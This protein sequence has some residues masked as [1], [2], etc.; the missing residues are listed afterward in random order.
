MKR[1]IFYLWDF[2]SRRSKRKRE[3]KPTGRYNWLL[4]KN[5][6]WNIC[7]TLY[8][9]GYARCTGRG[10]GRNNCCCVLVAVAVLWASSKLSCSGLIS[11]I[12]DDPIMPLSLRTPS[13]I[14]SALDS[15][16][17][18]A[19][20]KLKVFGGGGLTGQQGKWSVSKHGDISPNFVISN[21]SVPKTWRLSSA[22]QASATI[23]GHTSSG[24]SGTGTATPC[25][26]MLTSLAMPI[27][28]NDD[29][30]GTDSV[31][32]FIVVSWLVDEDSFS[33]LFTGVP[34]T[35]EAP[36]IKQNITTDFILR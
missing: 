10:A 35:I 3:S 34:F 27:L 12:L 9:G 5:D 23:H 16:L 1:N 28:P 8:V 29:D 32:S 20:V 11:G 31:K 26:E 36:I 15:P 21:W 24:D 6:C 14:N 22:L 7:G 33:G 18:S 30:L 2:H 17:K 4:Y 13:W 25:D 19:A